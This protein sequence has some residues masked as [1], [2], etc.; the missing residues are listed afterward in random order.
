MRACVRARARS[1]SWLAP[2]LLIL[3]NPLSMRALCGAHMV[4]WSHRKSCDSASLAAPALQH[5]CQ[6]EPRVLW[7]QQG[8]AC[9]LVLLVT[10]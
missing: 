10:V 7:S 1:L 2:P 6:V 3:H 5:T 4:L 8:A 9:R